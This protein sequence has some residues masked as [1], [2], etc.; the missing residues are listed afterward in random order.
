[1]QKGGLYEG[2][3]FALPLATGE[4]GWQ[5]AWGS[6]WAGRSS[7]AEFV[8]QERR[9]SSCIIASTAGCDTV[10]VAPPE[11]VLL[12]SPGHWHPES[13]SV[14]SHEAAGTFWWLL[15]LFCF[16]YLSKPGKFLNTTNVPQVLKASWVSLCWVIAWVFVACGGSSMDTPAWIPATPAMNAGWG[17]N[18][19]RLAL[20]T[21]TWGQWWIKSWP[22]A[23][24]ICW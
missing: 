12:F 11:Q 16:H 19:L 4:G 21:R 5:D 7:W 2:R 1:M 6:C 24:H 10:S 20:L 3:K 8:W 18:R 9:G 15:N 14:S 22:W 23:G 13:T 17:T